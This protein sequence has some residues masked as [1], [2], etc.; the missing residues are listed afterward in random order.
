MTKV[1]INF[2]SL[3]L[4]ARKEGIILCICVARRFMR[5]RFHKRVL[6][7]VSSL[8]SVLK[9]SSRYFCCFW[10]VEVFKFSIPQDNT[11]RCFLFL[12]KWIALHWR[13]PITQLPV[14]ESSTSLPWALS[15]QCIYRTLVSIRY[16]TNLHD[17]DMNNI[18]VG[19]SFKFLKKM[20][21]IW[22]YIVWKHDSDWSRYVK[23]VK[24]SKNG[25]T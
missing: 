24:L 11:L 19:Y 16:E 20:L 1:N 7:I 15:H 9:N 14:Q 10:P 5:G 13:F 23:E 17:K 21:R 12:L 2:L 25:D 4:L 18:V 8:V 3:I 22:N 6:C